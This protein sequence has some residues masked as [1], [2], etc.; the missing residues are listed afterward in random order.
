MNQAGDKLESITSATTAAETPVARGGTDAAVGDYTAIKSYVENNPDQKLK[1]IY[2]DQAF[3][4]NISASCSV[5]S[6]VNWD[7][8]KFISIFSKTK[9]ESKKIQ[10]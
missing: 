2:D 8:M 10:R 6:E 1:I 7:L 9:P 5:L 4:R 3:A